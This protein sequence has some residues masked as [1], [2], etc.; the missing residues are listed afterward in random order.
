[1]RL[2]NDDKFLIG[3]FGVLLIGTAVFIYIQA[4][5]WGPAEQAKRA[6]E[7][8]QA[9]II[10]EAKAVPVANKAEPKAEAAKKRFTAEFHGEFSGGWGNHVRAVYVVKDNQ[11]GVEYLAITGCGTTELKTE[12][13]QVKEGKSTVTKTRTVEE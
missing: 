5:V 1:M 9:A 10:A 6:E 11:T 12:Q 7:A 3:V 2:D 4:T 8:K 13:Y